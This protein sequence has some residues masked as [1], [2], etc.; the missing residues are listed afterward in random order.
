MPILKPNLASAISALNVNL[1][2]D[3]PSSDATLA[4]NYH[5]VGLQQLNSNLFVDAIKSF[6]EELKKRIKISPSSYTTLLTYIAGV[7]ADKI[8]TKSSD[9]ITLLQ[10]FQRL[11]GDDLLI[12]LVVEISRGTKRTFMFCTILW[13]RLMPI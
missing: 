12:K 1:S 13:W 11:V 3:T 5:K 10:H 4:D 6:Q 8:D 2:S 9:Y 7:Y